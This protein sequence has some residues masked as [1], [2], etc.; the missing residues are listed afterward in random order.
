MTDTFSSSRDTVTPAQAAERATLATGLTLASR[1]RL[2]LGV[3]AIGVLMAAG[4][5]GMLVAP[6]SHPAR[7]QAVL[8]EPGTPVTFADLAERVRP[9]V[10]SVRVKL[11]RPANVAS[12]DNEDDLA[13]FD[14]P[15]LERFLRRFGERGDPRGR[16]APRVFGESQGSGFFISADGYVVTNHHVVANGVD[17]TLVREDGS[18]LPAR[19]IGSDPK[20]D[21]ALLKV[22]AGE[23]FPFVRFAAASPRIGDW[24]LAV[25]N[26][27]GLGGTVTKGIVSARGRDIGA[28]PYDDFLQIDAAVNR[29]NSGGPT[30]N[31]SGEVVGVN[32][33]IVSPS[34]GSVGIAFAIP[35][36]TASRVIADLKAK[37]AVTRGFIGVSVQ[38]VTEAV[39]E[40]LGLQEATGVLVADLTAS[41]PAARAGLRRGDVILAVE[42]QALR[43]ARDLARRIAAIEPGRRVTL[44]IRRGGTEKTVTVEAGRQDQA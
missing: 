37:G 25:G 31:L 12:A 10:V 33:A 8:A 9:A 23:R 38:P 7:A 16:G 26:P 29:G 41:G 21:L 44:T 1:T 20:T 11:G 36:E 19:L 4:A 2:R 34:G 15:N 40:A 22:D 28:G 42:G 32:T 43:D 24:I 30:F 18:H 6:P 27:F 14:R 17:I 35:A 13:P 5:V 3:A 39:A